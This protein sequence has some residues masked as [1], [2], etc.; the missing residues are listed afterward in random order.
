[1]DSDCASGARCDSMTNRCVPRPAEDAGADA[2]IADASAADANRPNGDA[3]ASMD[4][5]AMDGGP[6]GVSGTGA[7]GCR[8][9]GGPTGDDRGI[10]ALALAGAAALFRAGRRRR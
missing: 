5:G 4:G 8:V 7:C 10:I 2:S 1:M 9:P 6:A 3:G